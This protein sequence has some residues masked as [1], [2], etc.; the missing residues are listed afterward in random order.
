MYHNYFSQL[1]KSRKR[2]WL[3]E[4][5][6]IHSFIIDNGQMDITMLVCGKK[7]CQAVSI[8]TLGISHS[9]FYNMRKKF[10]S[11]S[12]TVMSETQRSPLE[13]TSQAIAWLQN[14]VDLIGDHLPQRMIV[15][16]PSNLT[17]VAIYQRMVEDF[18]GRNYS[19]ISQSNFFK[20]WEEH[21]SYVTI[22]K[23]LIHA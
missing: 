3:L 7:V 23:V 2:T 19:L 4:Y 10:L 20:V 8:A 18:K 6:R 14:Y 13:K 12:I 21:F 16:L 11:G 5:F 15:H 1:P 22:P 9:F 17:K